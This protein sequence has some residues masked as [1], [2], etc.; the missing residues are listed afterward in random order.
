MGVCS[1]RR[2]DFLAIDSLLTLPAWPPPVAAPSEGI[3]FTADTCSTACTGRTAVPWFNRLSY[4]AVNHKHHE[5]GTGQRGQRQADLTHRCCTPWVRRFDEG[6]IREWVVEAPG[7]EGRDRPD[8]D[9][10]DEARYEDRRALYGDDRRVLRE[11]ETPSA[12]RMGGV[13][14]RI[15]GRLGLGG[16]LGGPHSDPPADQL[17][18]PQTA[19]GSNGG[20]RAIQ[21]ERSVRACHVRRCTGMLTVEFDA[22]ASTPPD[23][24]AAAEGI[25]PRHRKVSSPRL[26]ATLQRC[27]LAIVPPSAALCRPGRRVGWGGR[28][29]R[30]QG[31]PVIAHGRARGWPGDRRHRAPASV[32]ATRRPTA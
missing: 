20:P 13:P 25:W 28:P 12:H 18:E 7:D 17:L 31:P 29:A 19:P 8:E 3:R 6:P 24:A 15:G 9:V 5:D 2:P 26:R 1:L 23:L 14:E 30:A 27:R 22:S 11:A 4:S 16:H 10:P 21:D 32:R